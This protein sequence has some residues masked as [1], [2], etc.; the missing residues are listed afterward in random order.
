MA[1]FEYLKVVCIAGIWTDSLGNY[2]GKK[3]A[4]EHDCC[5]GAQ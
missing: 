5:G 1:V 4:N 2:K 3:F